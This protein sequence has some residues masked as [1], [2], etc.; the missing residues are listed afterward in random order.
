M[1]F[2]TKFPFIS[3]ESDVVKSDLEQ[4]MDVAEKNSI[5]VVVVPPAPAPVEEKISKIAQKVLDDLDKYPFPEWKPFTNS[6]VQET[7][8]NHNVS[9]ILVH[10]PAYH[11]YCF[12]YEFGVVGLNLKEVDIKAITKK[13]SFQRSEVARKQRE[14][15]CAETLEKMG[16]KLE[17]VKDELAYI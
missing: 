15:E 14:K 3:F 5:P 4:L 17:D 16:F 10:S 13:I 7:F 11:G 1:K 12:G 9:Y 6:N 2:T 8:N